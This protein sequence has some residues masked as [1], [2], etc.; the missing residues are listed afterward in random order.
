MSAATERA[1]GDHA[2]R[3]DVFNRDEKRVD[4]HDTTLWI[5]RQKRDKVARQIPDWELLRETAS[6][7]KHHTLSRLHEYLLQFEAAAQANGATVHWACLLY[8][9]PSPRDGLLSRMP[10]SA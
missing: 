7:I 2:H 9:S 10:S 5:V 4:W 3:A 6:Q 8:T 1:K